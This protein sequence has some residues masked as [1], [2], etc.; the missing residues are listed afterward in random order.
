MPP[1]QDS[2]HAF[3]RVMQ[4]LGFM[5][6][7]GWGAQLVAN[8]LWC[9]PLFLILAGIL[10]YARLVGKP[11]ENPAWPST[12]ARAFR[13]YTFVMWGLVVALV[14]GPLAGVNQAVARADRQAQQVAA[15]GAAAKR[16]KQEADEQVR[17]RELRARRAIELAKDLSATVANGDW[18]TSE[19]LLK[20]I[21]ELDPNIAELPKLQAIV[22]PKIAEEKAAAEEATRLVQLRAGLDAGRKL[23]LDAKE[24]KEP[25]SL[26]TVWEKVRRV[27]KVDAEWTAAKALLPKLEKCRQ[28]AVT[29]MLKTL[30]KLMID[31]R[32][33]T[34]D[35]A[36]R[37]MLA[38]GYDAEVTAS[39]KNKDQ[40]RF[41]YVLFNRALIFQITNGGTVG[42]DTFLGNYQKIGFKR[43]L[44]STGFGESWTYDLDPPSETG[45]AVGARAL[46]DVGM[47]EPFVLTE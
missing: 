44:F 32:V 27:R 6:L 25:R 33:R 7:T 4:T 24:C 36:D 2:S 35:E 5:A 15:D 31:Q 38:K 3:K 29:D 11:D 28:G 46:R 22:A 18:H 8:A 16:A 30:Q 10:I 14:L 47:E 19:T 34:A 37:L 17:Q 42:P 41:K 9:A 12:V 1:P 21:N 40:L 43:V 23:V 13:N 20:Q 45:P 39:G 26:P